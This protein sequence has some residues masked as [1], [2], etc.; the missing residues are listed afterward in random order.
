LRGTNAGLD[1]QRKSES[2]ANG[3]SSLSPAMSRNNVWFLISVVWVLVLLAVLI[4]IYFA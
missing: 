1:G 3:G 2:N 4:Y